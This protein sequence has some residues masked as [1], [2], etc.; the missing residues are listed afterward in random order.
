M[1][2]KTPKNILLIILVNDQNLAEQPFVCWFVFFFN[3]FLLTCVSGSI[4][5][6]N[7]IVVCTIYNDVVTHIQ[8]T[9]IFANIFMM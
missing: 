5:T 6:V 2:S 7:H 3:F 8:Y 4:C 1:G 9:C